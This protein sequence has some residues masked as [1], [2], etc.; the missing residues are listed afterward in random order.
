[1]EAGRLGLQ[2]RL[3]RKGGE[4]MG[5]KYVRGWLVVGLGL[6]YLGGNASIEQSPGEGWECVKCDG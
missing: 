1:M 6:L 4:I 3:A 2:S 5:K